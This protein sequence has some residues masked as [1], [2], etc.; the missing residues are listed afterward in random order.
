MI[1]IAYPGSFR[2]QFCLS[3]DLF[4]D[5]TAG[6]ATVRTFYRGN[7]QQPVEFKIV[8]TKNNYV[9]TPSPPPVEPAHYKVLRNILHNGMVAII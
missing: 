8:G 7:L 5:L 4:T 9:P 1:Q 6:E 2:T 3:R